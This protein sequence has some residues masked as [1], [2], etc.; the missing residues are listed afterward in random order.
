VKDVS[1]RPHYYLVP[2][3]ATATTFPPPVTDVRAYMLQAAHGRR[4]PLCT[5][6]IIIST[7]TRVIYDAVVACCARCRRVCLAGVVS[8]C[9]PLAGPLKSVEARGETS[10]TPVAA[11]HSGFIKAG[12]SMLEVS[13][14]IPTTT[15]TATSKRLQD[16]YYPL[17]VP[18]TP[19][20]STCLAVIAGLAPSSYSTATRASHDSLLACRSLSLLFLLSRSSWL[21]GRS[22]YSLSFLGFD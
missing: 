6:I 9:V 14:F 15:T 17:H 21:A 16:T 11:A 4:R 8:A 7:Q 13:L 18:P 1:L 19:A 22:R 3:A 10:E 2:S 20:S 5:C 12:R